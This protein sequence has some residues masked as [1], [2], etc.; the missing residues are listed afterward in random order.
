MTTTNGSSIHYLYGCGSGPDA[1]EGEAHYND[2]LGFELRLEKE[3]RVSGCFQ[4]PPRSEPDKSTKNG[5]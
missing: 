3:F 4:L 5:V 1:G 2:L